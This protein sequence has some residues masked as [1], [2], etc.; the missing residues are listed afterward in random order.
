ME[1]LRGLLRGVVGGVSTGGYVEEERRFIYNHIHSTVPHYVFTEK[2]HLH[3]Y[4]AIVHVHHY[5]KQLLY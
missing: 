3:V 5:D 2:A 1:S 4:I